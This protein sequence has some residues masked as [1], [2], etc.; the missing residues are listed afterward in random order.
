MLKDC[1]ELL[2]PFNQKLNKEE[3]E[4]IVS[5]DSALNIS[6]SLVNELYPWASWTSGPKIGP[7]A[8]RNHG[9]KIAH[10]DWL[11][12]IDDDTLP[13]KELLLSYKTAITTIESKVFEGSTDVD[14]KRKRLDEVSPINLEGDNLWS[15]NF[16]I[17]A[18][19]FETLGGFDEKFPYPALED[20][21]LLLRIK[22]TERVVFLSNAKVIHPWRRM[23]PFQSY[24]KWIQSNKYLFQ[25]HQV[26][27]DFSF[28]LKRFKILLSEVVTMTADLI[29]YS[30]KGVGYYFEKLLF[31]TLMIFI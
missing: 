3:Y 9:S 27:V 11:I 2:S 25:K 31:N 24:H 26:K 21:D 7:A 28:R 29:K 8:N 10:G 4:V 23:K 17:Q 13:G 22:K 6:K 15:C 19:F 20:T 12:F 5:D 30:F 14:R 1:L 16:A 18:A